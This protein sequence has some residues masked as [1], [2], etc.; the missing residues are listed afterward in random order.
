VSVVVI[1]T[2]IVYIAASLKKVTCAKFDIWIRISITS[3]SVP[4]AVA[5][6]LDETHLQK[7][8]NKLNFKTILTECFDLQVKN[9]H[10]PTLPTDFSALFCWC[11]AKKFFWDQKY[12]KHWNNLKILSRKILKKYSIV[13][14][15]GIFPTNANTT[16]LHSEIFCLYTPRYTRLFLFLALIHRTAKNAYMV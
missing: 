2:T 5:K 15:H 10:L 3:H 11:L 9:L 12:N 6:M 13:E 7:P 16:Q 14:F 4:R 1:I 8:N